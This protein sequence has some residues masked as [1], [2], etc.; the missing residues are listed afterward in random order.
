MTVK[1]AISNYKALVEKAD[2]LKIVKV[3]AVKKR[4]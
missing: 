2:K 1:K 3:K 4:R